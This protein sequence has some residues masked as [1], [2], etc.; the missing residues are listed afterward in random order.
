VNRH[1]EQ[2]CALVETLT[3]WLHFE[4]NCGR[5]NAF[6]EKYLVSPIFQFLEHRHPGRVQTNVA[7]PVLIDKEKVDFAVI[8]GGK[9]EIAVETKWLNEQ[10]PR[11]A[12]ALSRI[13]K[14]LL[15]LELIARRFN[16]D[17]AWFVLGGRKVLFDRLWNEKYSQNYRLAAE[18][19]LPYNHARVGLDPE[20][21]Y[22]GKPIPAH[23]SIVRGLIE[24]ACKK[25]RNVDLGRNFDVY[26]EKPFSRCAVGEGDRKK[27]FVP[28]HS[29]AVYG[30]RVG[31]AKHCFRP[32]V[33]FS[34]GA[35]PTG[36]LL[37]G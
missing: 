3:S 4:A 21:D 7:H 25:F 20:I 30:W 27:Y 18:H 19:L 33:E 10:S 8:E 17:Q 23:R 24:L 12:E 14:D 35:L 34:L 37:D 26:P 9:W 6:E 13:V 28:P 2:L 1:D 11:S 32:E 29:Y 5:E 16:C 36:N 31:A 15:R 22:V